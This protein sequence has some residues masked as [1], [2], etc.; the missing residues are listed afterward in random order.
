MGVLVRH[1]IDRLLFR[2]SADFDVADG[3][4][5]MD[6]PVSEL[7]IEE[8]A[9]A[10]HQRHHAHGDD[11]T[12]THTRTGSPPL[13]AS[14]RLLGARSVY[15]ASI[16][17]RGRRLAAAARTTLNATDLNVVAPT[18]ARRVLMGG[19]LRGRGSP[20]RPNAVVE[21]LIADATGCRRR[22]GARLATRGLGVDT[23]ALTRA[24]SARLSAALLLSIRR[25]LRS[26]FITRRLCG[27]Y[28]GVSDFIDTSGRAKRA[29]LFRA[30]RAV[31][32]RARGGG[33]ASRGRRRNG[34]W[35]STAVRIA[36]RE[37]PAPSLSARM[38][39]RILAIP[40]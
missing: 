18:R 15:T 13:L 14:A 11:D 36:H 34:A 32:A 17:A 19:A 5:G 8:K 33:I 3:N 22:R 2:L 21:R 12:P 40:C 9:R 28:R 23:R 4:A 38:A 29:H 26:A 39:M 30:G 31:H 24:W 35:A 27:A 25:R 6:L 16:R 20:F 37:L 1:E 10:K 7:M